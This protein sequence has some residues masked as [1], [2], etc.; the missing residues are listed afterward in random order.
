[1]P[2]S[3]ISHA[4]LEASISCRRME[5]SCNLTAIEQN[6]D[7]KSSRDTSQLLLHGR[8]ADCNVWYLLFT[9]AVTHNRK[10]SYN[11]IEGVCGFLPFCICDCDS[12]MKKTA[13]GGTGVLPP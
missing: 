3:I 2:T 1:M 12:A 4:P 13:F 6:R 9:V 7:Y 8:K 10:G 5:T 11:V